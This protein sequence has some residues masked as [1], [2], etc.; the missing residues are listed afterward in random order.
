MLMIGFVLL[1]HIN[2]AKSDGFCTHLCTGNCR[3]GRLVS[4]LVCAL[5]PVNH[6]GLGLETNLNPSPTYSAKNSSKSTKLDHQVLTQIQ[7][8]NT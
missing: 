8:L 3:K 1:A 6:K 4:L 5:S 2:V 7:T